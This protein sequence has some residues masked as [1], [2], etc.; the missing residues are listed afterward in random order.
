MREFYLQ[1]R[2]RNWLVRL[3]HWL[4]RGLYLRVR[5]L[6]WPVLSSARGV[7][8]GVV[9]GIG[10]VFDPPRVNMDGRGGDLCRLCRLCGVCGCAAK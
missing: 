10:G 2:G 3:A 7:M 9:A 1:V 4:V 5:E 8:C 6:Y